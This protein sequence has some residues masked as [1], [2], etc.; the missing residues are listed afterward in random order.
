MPNPD[1]LTA[2]INAW[3][4]GDPLALDRFAPLVYDEL[5]RLARG[6][7]R[8][9]NPGHTLQPTAL[10]NEAFL[11]LANVRLDYADRKHFLGMASHVMRCV[12]VDHARGRRSQKRGGSHQRVTLDDAKL[13]ADLPAAE[14]LDVDRALEQL[15]EQE[16]RLVRLI[17]LVYFGGLTAEE[18]AEVL[19]TSRS[20]L[21]ED[22]RFAKA[23]LKLALSELQPTD[24]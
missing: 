22:L 4:N 23:W 21:F 15:G 11:R 19:G 3:K 17:E 24:S 5:R 1:E 10:V 8:A 7:M 16:P 18:V 2:D 13:A 14:I 6:H 9:E 20:Q 12:L